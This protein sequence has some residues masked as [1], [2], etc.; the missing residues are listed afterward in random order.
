MAAT[1]EQRIAYVQQVIADANNQAQRDVQVKRDE[2][3][4]LLDD[5]ILKER[6]W[7]GNPASNALKQAAADARQTY[8]SNRSAFTTS[9]DTALSTAQAAVDAA[10]AAVKDNAWTPPS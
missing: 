2:M 1:V 8:T 9:V 3:V 10:W 5:F 6:N 7:L 4:T